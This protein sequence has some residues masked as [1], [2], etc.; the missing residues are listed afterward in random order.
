MQSFRCAAVLTLLLA[1]QILLSCSSPTG[2]T[3]ASNAA[4]N[5]STN[6]AVAGPNDN[7]DELMLLLRLPLEPEEVAW[8][9][10]P[11]KKSLVAVIRFSAEN[12]AK[13]EAEAAKAGQPTPESIAVETWY[14]A[15][16]IAQGELSGESTVK[17]HSYPAEPFL[18]PPYAKGKITRIENTD[19]FILQISS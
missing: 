17:G 5:N 4:A 3:N 6:A 9:E 2:N 10:D 19:Y 1:S 15:E 8:D 16:L 18:N 11:S 13:M 12:A 7:V 14:P